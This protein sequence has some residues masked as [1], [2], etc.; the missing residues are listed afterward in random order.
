MKK[1][2]LRYFKHLIFTIIIALPILIMVGHANGAAANYG[3]SSRIIDWDR[4][5]PYIF[6]ENDSTL[7]VNYVRGDKDEGFYVDT[8][9]HPADHPALVTCFNP[10]DSSSFEFSLWSTHLSNGGAFSK[11]VELHRSNSEERSKDQRRR[12]QVKANEKSKERSSRTRTDEE[13]E[14]RFSENQLIDIASNQA[15][16]TDGQPIIAI[17]DIEGNY[18]AFRD[19]L[20]G[21]QVID[22]DLN[23]TFNQGHLVLVGD[24]VDRGFF[25]TQVL[26]L[27]YKLDHEAKSAGGNVHFIIGNHELKNLYGD[28]GS[29]SPKYQHIAS[30]L[31]KQQYELY[32]INSL[33]GRWME[34]KNILEVING[35]LFVHGGIHPE[36]AD[37]EMDITEMNRILKSSYREPY[38][39]KKDKDPNQLL[40]SSRTGP[41]WYRGYFKADLSQ[42][43]IDRGLEKFGAKAVVVGHTMQMKLSRNFDGKVFGIDVRHPADHYKIFPF[44]SSEGLL[45]KDG[46]YFRVFAD[47]KQR[48]I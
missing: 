24:F 23:W 2:I 41:A 33:I 31:G 22:Q 27:I 43:E 13:Q 46:N 42:E 35:V 16:F 30:M 10:F 32:G 9:F 47:G 36:I 45:I 19:F 18:L 38:F 5:G 21:N 29:A 1:R 15:I 6:F 11:G 3:H 4:E 25:S 26:W 7:S 12:S 20:I 17:S 39:P 8:E 48:R 44:P 40:K 28:Y 14:V 37:L 34:T